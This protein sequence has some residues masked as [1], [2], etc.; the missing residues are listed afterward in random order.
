MRP[1]TLW[2]Y[3]STLLRAVEVAVTGG[4]S[5]CALP[6]LTRILG[7]QE[8]SEQQQQ[9][10]PRNNNILQVKWFFIAGLESHL[11]HEPHVR[12]PYRAS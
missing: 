5:C 6:A 3:R 8:P 9:P 1:A 12:V 4:A 10:P 7:H 11:N 2:P